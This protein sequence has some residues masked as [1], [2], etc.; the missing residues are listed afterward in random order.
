MTAT[1]SAESYSKLTAA[2]IDI[3]LVEEF[4][5]TWTQLGRLLGW[6]DRT[7]ARYKK[8]ECDGRLPLSVDRTLELGR[9][10]K[11]IW[12]RHEGTRSW[13]PKSKARVEK[14]SYDLTAAQRRLVLHM[15]S[16][17]QFAR[18]PFLDELPKDSVFISEGALIERYHLRDDLFRLTTLGVDVHRYISAP[19][20]RG[21]DEGHVRAAKHAELTHRQ[22][23]TALG[24]MGVSLGKFR[25]DSGKAARTIEKI[26]NGVQNDDI[27][28]DIQTLLYLYLIDEGARRSPNLMPPFKEYGIDPGEP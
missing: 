25:H 18:I 1:K 17:R 24:Q 3:I 19:V 13:V 2:E 4:S 12:R 28:A 22:I 7:L 14:G 27:P 11:S 16:D 10:D 23:I 26:L 8:G 6:S 9:F 15:P 20:T 21:R 5:T